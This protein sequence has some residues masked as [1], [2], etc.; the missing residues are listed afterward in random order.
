MRVM[1]KICVVAMG[2]ALALSMVGGPAHAAQRAGLTVTQVEPCFVVYDNTFYYNFNLSAS[3]GI[4]KSNILCPK[5]GWEDKLNAGTSL[6]ETE[7]KNAVGAANKYPGPFVINIEAGWLAGPDTTL[8]EKRAAVWIEILQ[9]TA[10]VVGSKPIGVYHFHEQVR[11]DQP[12]V[13][14][15]RDVSQ[16]LDIFVSSDYT[17]N[18]DLTTWEAALSN[19]I[20]RANN[21]D[22]NKPFYSYVWSNYH[23]NSQ[24]DV[25]I[26]PS[27]WRDQLKI[28]RQRVDSIVIWSSTNYPTITRSKAGWIGETD[29][30]VD[31]LPTPPA[32]AM[33]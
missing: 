26:T 13:T 3:I 8:V 16:Y 30:F 12:H 33:P 22:A 4:P 7:Y 18:N 24:D 17:A 25:F 10:Q 28:L 6:D 20:D 15:A 19:S 14:L 1:R 9:W 32:C 23:P 29:V 11:W 21:L 31:T 27:V 5:A 2:I